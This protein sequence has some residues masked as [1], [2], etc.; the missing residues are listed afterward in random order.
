MKTSRLLS[1][2]AFVCVVILALIETEANL[3]YLSFQRVQ[4]F[5]DIDLYG[6]TYSPKSGQFVAVGDGGYIATSFDGVTWQTSLSRT[7]ADLRAITYRYSATSTDTYV[8]VGSH[9]TI[10]LSKDGNSWIE[11]EKVTDKNLKSVTNRG[12][13]FVA[14]GQNGVVVRSEG[15]VRWETLE[16][17]VQVDL[18]AVVNGNGLFVAVGD[19][20]TI[21]LSEDAKYWRQVKSPISSHLRGIAFGNGIFTAVGDGG[22]V[23]RSIDGENWV[24]QASRTGNYLRAVSFGDSKFLATGQGGTIVYSPD[25]I[26][27]QQLHT[28]INTG[29]NAVL[30]RNNILVAVGYGGNVLKAQNSYLIANPSIMNFG[31]VAPG[32]SLTQSF[33]VINIG[34]TPLEI[35]SVTRYGD[36]QFSI[37]NDQCSGVTLQKSGT[38]R[39]DVRFTSGVAGLNKAS[40]VVRSSSA[41]IATTLSLLAT[42]TGVLHTLTIQRQ[43]DGNVYSSPDGI[44]CG[45]S[46]STSILGGTKVRL[47]AIPQPGASFVQ[48]TGLQDCTT[49]NPCTFTI[50][51]NVAVTATFQ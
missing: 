32:L 5:S 2:A 31:S 10:V 47:F 29:L 21:I 7:D 4:A 46:C 43:G 11:T 38:C 51:G 17:I 26:T 22:V 27:W 37:I 13:L 8:A 34:D 42:S 23:L 18:N 20:G 45:N 33:A 40:I 39:V 28:G 44:D 36:E 35:S 25:A 41:P 48:W 15:A 12:S 6:I 50:N 14:V 24:Q 30:M 9:G 19:R 1:L 3:S 49:N 16:P